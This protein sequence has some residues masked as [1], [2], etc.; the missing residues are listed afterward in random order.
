MRNAGLDH[1]LVRDYLRQLDAALVTLPTAHARELKLQITAHLDEALRPGMD[2][3]GIAAE[4]DRLGTPADL[5]AE[6]GAATPVPLSQAIKVTTRVRLGRVSAHIWIRLG[7]AL[8]IVGMIASYLVYY[9][10]AGSLEE[11]PQSVWWYPQD[12]ARQ[13]ITTADGAT[14]Y[15]VP[16]RSG[17]RQGFEIGIYNPTDVTQTVVGAPNVPGVNTPAAQKAEVAV[18]VPNRDINGGGT[19]RNIRFTLPAAIAPHQIR[20][21]R[22]MWVSDICEAKGAA[23]I[24]DEISLKVRIGWFTKTETIPLAEGWAVS[25]TAE[26]ECH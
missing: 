13:V 20:L 25:G 24:M 4:L 14:Q 3:A 10:A 1:L 16:I 5:A 11:G 8:A 9:L 26:S 12:A 22:I 2:D 18:S 6:A 15:T 7:V 17:Q 19:T 21:L 23:T